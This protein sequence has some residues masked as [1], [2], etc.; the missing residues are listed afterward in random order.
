MINNPDYF[1]KIAPDEFGFIEA[2]VQS[3]FNSTFPEWVLLSCGLHF[4]V[5]NGTEY[6]SSGAYIPEPTEMV[7]KLQ[8]DCEDQSV[9]L[10]SLYIASGLEPRFVIISDAYGN[11][12]HVLT[13]V[14]CSVPDTDT[15]HSV[16]ETFYQEELDMRIETVSWE[17]SSDSGYWYVAD[18]EFS[19]YIGDIKSLKRDDYIRD[20]G[21]GWEWCHCREIQ[22]LR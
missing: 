11:N 14:Y 2:D 13:E 4:L 15:T 1:S 8:G 12:P 22:S 9:L 16:L 10:A 7:D 18:P 20:T 21:S 17:H 6:F 3:R 5:S 19:R